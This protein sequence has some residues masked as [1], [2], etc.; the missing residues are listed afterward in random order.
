M[1]RWFECPYLGESVELTDER[2]AH[3]RAY[4]PELLAS[5]YDLV[6]ATLTE[7]DLIREDADRADTLLFSRWYDEPAHRR[8][9]RYA[10]VAVVIDRAPV[11]RNWII[12]AYVARRVPERD[13]IWR[14]S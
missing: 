13:V 8:G 2:E 14:R 7:P 12:T 3:V 4:H 9:G 10:V 6:D 11:P 1:A 5:G